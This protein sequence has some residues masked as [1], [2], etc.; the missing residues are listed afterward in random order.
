[1][2]GNQHTVA[3]KNSLEVLV[4]SASE[5]DMSF[6]QV[7]NDLNAA[8]NNGRPMTITKADAVVPGAVITTTPAAPARTS[9]LTEP[10]AALDEDVPKLPS[11]NETSDIVQFGDVQIGQSMTSPTMTAISKVA[12]RTNI[13]MT[14]STAATTVTATPSPTAAPTTTAV[15]VAGQPT[16]Q[17]TDNERDVSDIVVSTTEE[18]EAESADDTYD[19][20]SALSASTASEREGVAEMDEI[21]QG[22]EETQVVS[23]NFLS[24]LSTATAAANSNDVAAASGEKNHDNMK[25]IYVT[26]PNAPWVC[27]EFALNSEHICVQALCFGLDGCYNRQFEKN[28][29]VEMQPG[30]IRKIGGRVRVAKRNPYE[31][32]ARALEPRKEKVCQHNVKTG[33]VMVNDLRFMFGSH[34]E[35][36]TKNGGHLPTH[37]SGCGGKFIKGMK[38]AGK[39]KRK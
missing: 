39:R 26:K 2:T 7:I 15:P 32:C 37:C 38:A 30:T 20:P 17:L 35:T 34:L 4:K 24:S 21:V 27:R 22:G 29:G 31:A 28:V 36:A 3:Y 14:T 11:L 33:Y 23:C 13:P 18:T 19:F 1:M 10:M 12:V 8:M 25:E 5:L 16:V 9:S 6:E